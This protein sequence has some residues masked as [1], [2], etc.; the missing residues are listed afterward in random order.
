MPPD[1]EPLRP[2]LPRVLLNL[3]RRK[4]AHAKFHCIAMFVD[5]SGFTPL[6]EAFAKQGNAGAEEITVIIN[7]FF[8]A[9]IAVIQTHSGDIVG[10]GGDAMSVVFACRPSR[11]ASAARRVWHCALALQR[12]ATQFAQVETS[13]GTFPL[14]IKIGLGQGS[15]VGEVIGKPGGEARFLAHGSALAFANEAEHGARAG[16]VMAHDSLAIGLPPQTKAQ[17][18]VSPRSRSSTTPIEIHADGA[19][20]LH[21]ALVQ[22]VL[23][24]SAFVN[25]HRKV[26]IVFAGIDTTD[27]LGTAMQCVHDWDGCVARLDTNNNR[28]RMLILFGAPIAHE[29]DEARALR[30]ALHMRERLPSLQIG[31]CTGFVFCGDVGG[32][33]TGGARREYTVMGDAVNLAARLLQNTSPGQILVSA[34]TAPTSAFVWQA[35]PS[36]RVKGKTEPVQV[37]QL[38][39]LAAEA[40]IAAASHAVSPPTMLL[41]RT[42]EI[43]HIQNLLRA[44]QHG[45]GHVIQLVAE[46]GL[47]KSRLAR[48]VAHWAAQN[49]FEVHRSAGQ[50]YGQSA[51]AAWRGLLRSLMHIAPDESDSR[52]TA[53]A[54]AW[55]TEHQLDEPTQLA[56]LLTVLGTSA[57]QEADFKWLQ[58]L[59]LTT[60]Q[61]LLHAA[62]RA[63]LRAH[64]HTHAHTRQRPTLLVFDDAHWLDAASLDLLRD[65]STHVSDMPLAILVLHRPAV[66]SIENASQLQLRELP[67][68][69]AQQLAWHTWQHQFDTAPPAHT[70]EAIVQRA[71]GNPFFIEQLI[72]FARQRGGF[73]PAEVPDTLRSLLLS[74]MDQLTL[75]AQTVLKVASVIGPQLNATWVRACWPTSARIPQDEI[76][77][78]LMQLV[79]LNL[80]QPEAEPAWATH[81]FRHATVREVAYDSLAFATRA[82]LHEKAGFA[83]EHSVEQNTA[84]ASTFLELLAHHF[85]HSHNVGKQRVYFRKAGDAAK[86]AFA[87][88]LAISHYEDLLKVLPAQD[89]AASRSDALVQ[90]GSVQEHIGD[91]A[92]AEDRYRQSLSASQAVQATRETANGLRALG[93]LLSRRQSHAAAV[94]WLSQ[95]AAA[96][97][98]LDDPIG[99]C[100]T[101]SYLSFAQLELGR[102]DE[103]ERLARQQYEVA[104]TANDVTGQCDALQVLGQIH[105]QENRFEA[106]RDALNLAHQLAAMQH[107]LIGEILL[108]ND[109]ALLHW[110]SG[111]PDAALGQLTSALA[112]A[113]R[114]GYTVWV[115]ILTN[116]I[117]DLCRELG[118]LDEAERCVAV[119]LD[120]ALQLGDQANLLTCLGNAAYV[121]RDQGH[122]VA[123]EAALRDAVRLGQHLQMPAQQAEY[124]QA[125]E[126]LAAGLHIKQN[127]T[128]DRL[129]HHFNLASVIDEQVTPP[130]LPTLLTRAHEQVEA[131]STEKPQ[132]NS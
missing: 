20:L 61:Q 35:L 70:V 65:V 85:G 129:P 14:A 122:I 22:R 89:F 84:T 118:G 55:L 57:S 101:L 130:D 66:L 107:D 2:Y 31:L 62:C 58:Q 1:Y 74:R 59:D 126:A 110:R 71:Q 132:T 98:A 32:T 6:T 7:R 112:V 26:T 56:L 99:L 24:H 120:L 105:L 111:D 97:A 39:S 94:D 36:L 100:R 119:A 83:I 86:D 18:P 5:V 45:R 27:A 34:T 82:A 19:H 80:L 68:N 51:Y 3:L 28:L 115:C 67:A 41:G 48:E 23:A 30:C 29:D 93:S 40:K 108:G 16:E 25:E 125:L 87:N 73:N 49:G 95:A 17:A 113:R 127:A 38:Q 43:A 63:C 72:S 75:A 44:A 128:Q 103:A 15:F 117:G 8:E 121:R 53:R 13:V 114:I 50:P 47:G 9:L 46:A 69:D 102:L 106:A 116:N 4:S 91:W 11:A 42:R 60:R 76:N 21:P 78:E 12:A 90:L 79:Q 96:F 77:A 109:L 131:L 81:A 123:A 54:R 88:D 10:F 92:Q 33:G 104:T 124:A 37:R 52:T 64:M